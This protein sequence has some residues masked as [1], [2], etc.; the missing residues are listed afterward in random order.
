MKNPDAPQVPI[1]QH[2]DV[3]RHLLWMKA[4]VE[5]CRALNYYTG[6]CMDMMEAAPT[7]EERQVAGPPNCSSRSARPM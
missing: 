1:I 4:H 2:P 6:Y 7:K 3:R 5:G